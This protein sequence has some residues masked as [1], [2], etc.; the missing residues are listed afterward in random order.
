M[1][2]HTIP[3]NSPTHPSY[4]T[5]L[6]D[7]YDT[8]HLGKRVTMILERWRGS[9]ELGLPI[10]KMDRWVSKQE[11]ANATLALKLYITVHFDSDS[12]GCL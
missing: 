1:F 4:T 3:L 9:L 11:S 12:E 8:H 2:Y 7:S 10:A 6:R 5:P